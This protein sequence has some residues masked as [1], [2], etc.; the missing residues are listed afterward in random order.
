MKWRAFRWPEIAPLPGG[1]AP[2]S[3][4]VRLAYLLGIWTASVLAVLGIAQLI[5]LALH[6]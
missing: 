6:P 4:W 3:W 5:R 2:G 1:R